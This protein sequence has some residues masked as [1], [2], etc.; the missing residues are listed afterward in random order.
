M[1][2]QDEFKLRGD[3]VQRDME[4]FDITLKDLGGTAVGPSANSGHLLK[5]AIACGWIEEPEGEAGDFKDGRR[6]M[7][8]GLNVD[9]MQPGK[10]LWYGGQVGKVYAAAL[11]IPPN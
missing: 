7:L 11:K 2:W 10:V 9:D 1:G 4:A 5:A 8:G 6:Y 3:L